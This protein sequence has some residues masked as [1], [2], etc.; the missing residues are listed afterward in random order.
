MI[1]DVVIFFFAHLL[2]NQVNS[3]DN[4]SLIKKIKNKQKRM[5]K[6]SKDFRY[7]YTTNECGHCPPDT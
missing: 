1:V 4:N 6:K 3:F 7:V 5:E 2:P